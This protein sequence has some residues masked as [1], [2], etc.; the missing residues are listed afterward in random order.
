MLDLVAHV[1]EK[2]R[3]RDL[4]ALGERFLLAV[5]GGVDSIVLLD[6]LHRVGRGR[7][8]RLRIAHLNHQLRGVSSLADERL[9]HSMARRMKIPIT[10]ERADVRGIARARKISIEMA[11]REA[12]H[13][14]LARIAERHRIRS[15]ALA[16][17][18]D[19]QVELFF[20]RLLRGS[21]MEALAGMKWRSPS[22]ARPNI[23]LVRPLLD[24]P[25]A[26]LY[27]YAEARKLAFREDATNESTDFL[28]N[29]IRHELLPLLTRKYE[30]SLPATVLRTIEILAAENDFVASSAAAWL[31]KRELPFH[32]LPLALQRRALHEQLVNTGLTP[33][34]ELIEKLRLKP[35]RAVSVS[36]N[37]QAVVRQRDGTIRIRRTVPQTSREEV[38][39][40]ELHNAAP[41]QTEFA[42]KNL[43]WSFSAPPPGGV[44]KSRKGREFF[45]ADQVGSPIFL[46]HWRPGDRFQ[47][48]GMSSAIKLQDLFVNQKVPRERRHNLT[49]ATTAD[50]EIFWVQD[51][52]ISERFKLTKRTKRRLQWIWEPV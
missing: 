5:S 24:V 31:K 29:R 41:G 25:K 28:R 14:F 18:A 45:D 1:V 8:W 52:R 43:K 49:V 50:G 27:A 34:F 32:R 37:G 4:F 23:A 15:I 16:H 48:I 19:D 10:V 42:G 3:A 36:P 30:R 47:P 39:M 38:Q 35:E 21:G 12:R 33:T 6:L 17:H 13:R 9:V 26:E 11:A 20:L 44:L 2:I 7:G 40:V 46:R 51:L 22:P